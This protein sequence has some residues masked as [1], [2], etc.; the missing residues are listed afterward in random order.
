MYKTLYN[1]S[2]GQVPSKHF[3][4]LEGAPAFLEGG[5]APVPW[6]N[7]TMANPSLENMCYTCQQFV[8]LVFPDGP[9]QQDE[10]EQKY[11]GDQY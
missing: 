11:H 2:R 3:I 5:R 4:F 7:E 10:K 1:I 8:L 6:Y 9:I